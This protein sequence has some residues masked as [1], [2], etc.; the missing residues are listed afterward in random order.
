MS[1]RNDAAARALPTNAGD[2]ATRQ[3]G[4][5][6][7]AEEGSSAGGENVP[8]PEGLGRAPRGDLATIR[9]NAKRAPNGSVY[10]Q[11]RAFARGIEI[12]EVRASSP[13]AALAGAKE[14]VT[15]AWSHDG[16]TGANTNQAGNTDTSK[17]G[18]SGQ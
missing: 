2:P 12:G 4:A 6:A 10:F 14:S 9:V 8:A 17:G 18:G 5:G 13:E 3:L 7:P 16:A 11:A 1:G 15:S